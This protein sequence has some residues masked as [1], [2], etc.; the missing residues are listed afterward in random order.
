MKHPKDSNPVNFFWKSSLFHDLAMTNFAHKNFTEAFTNLTGFNDFKHKFENLL[1]QHQQSNLKL[2]DL[3]ES[4]TIDLWIKRIMECLG[5]E[6]ADK[7]NGLSNITLNSENKILR[8]DLIY[9]NS[10]EEMADIAS[11]QNN[12]SLLIKRLK[13]STNIILEAK[14]YGRIQ[15]L[16]SKYFVHESSKED[17]LAGNTSFSSFEEQITSYQEV[18]SVDFGILTDGKIWRLTHKNL[19]QNE[20][21]IFEFNLTEL[22]QLAWSGLDIDSGREKFDYYARYFYAVFSKQSHQKNR[23]GKTIIA[24]ML[25]FSQKYTDLSKKDLTFRFIKTM[26]VACNALDKITGRKFDEFTTIR[27]CA[28]NHIFTILFIRFCEVNGILSLGIP[29][30]EQVSI[31]DIAERLQLSNFRPDQPVGNQIAKLKQFF[32]DDFD[33]KGHSLYERYLN[34]VQSLC[35]QK[36]SIGIESFKEAMFGSEGWDFA[37]KAKISNEEMISII[38]NLMFTS[39]ETDSPWEYQQIPYAVFTPR[40]LG[41]IYESLLQFKLERAKQNWN[42]VEDEWVSDISNDETPTGESGDF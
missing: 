39:G 42:L 35:T 32:G 37:K 26:T 12:P 13:N 19:T 2:N 41:S 3:N 21:K 17:R 4:Q 27:D 31:S 18:L 16:N 7:P 11:V 15:G 6:S 9:L 20:G 38:F 33:I 30:Y 28:E 25:N 34:L 14:Y 36:F 40:E 29:L 24:D 22:C 5:W 10:S 1:E 8:P 23:S